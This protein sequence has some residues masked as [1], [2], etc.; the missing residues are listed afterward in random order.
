MTVSKILEK[1]KEIEEELEQTDYHLKKAR[2]LL[3][4]LQEKAQEHEMR[5]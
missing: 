4:E 1:I 3:S 2:H 5:K